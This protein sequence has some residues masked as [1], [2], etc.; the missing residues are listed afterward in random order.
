MLISQHG[1]TAHIYFYQRKCTHKKSCLIQ[2]CCSKQHQ[3]AQILKVKEPLLSEI[4]FLYREKLLSYSF[5]VGL[6]QGNEPGV[7]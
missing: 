1:S 3:L 4:T 5:T 7:G 6:W 2:Q